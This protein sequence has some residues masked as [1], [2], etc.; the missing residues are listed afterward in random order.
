MKA[1][2]AYYRI[3]GALMVD[4]YVPIRIRRFRGDFFSASRGSMTFDDWDGFSIYLEDY[5]IEYCYAYNQ[6]DADDYD[7]CNGDDEAFIE[8][9]VYLDHDDVEYKDIIR[10]KT[11]GT[12][13]HYDDEIDSYVV[14]I[15]DDAKELFDAIDHATVCAIEYLEEYESEYHADHDWEDYEDWRNEMEFERSRGN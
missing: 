14:K 13:D 10:I 1:V 2:E 5:P 6:R 15:D 7:E 4:R 3:I 8:C 12:S 9:H 11:Y